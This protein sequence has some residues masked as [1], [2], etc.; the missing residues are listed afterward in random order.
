MKTSY[1]LL[2]SIILLIITY[3]SIAQQGWTIYNNTNTILGSGTYKA[4]SIDQLGNIWVGGSYNGLYK[5][6]GTTWTKYS[7]SNSNILHNDI[8][9]IV[10]D[11]ANKVW[12]ANY[13]GVSVFNGSTFA[14][15]DTLNA[16]F[17]GLT[18]YTLGKDNNGKIWL[19]SRTGS[20]GYKG[21]T[22]FDG[23]TWTNITGYP[24]QINGA[25]FPDFAFASNNDAWIACQNG[26]TK[27]NGAFTYYP[28]VTSISK[29]QSVAIDANGNVWVG[30]FSALVKYNGSTWTK[31][32]N[33]T[34]LGLISSNTLYYDIFPDGNILWIG[35]SGGLLKF[36]ITTGTIV[37]NYNSSNSPLVD[38]CVSKITK[39]ASG[40]LW[41]ATT[42]GVV[43]MDPSIVGVEELD[44][45]N[46]VKIYP[47][48]TSNQ[49]YIESDLSKF[50]ITIIDF[51][52]K[53]IK[54]IKQNTNFVD[55]T[56]LSNGIYFIKVFTVNGTIT[57]KFIKQ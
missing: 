41:L 45:N 23:T 31:Y 8:N 28:P 48:P 11:N 49:L 12:V 25:E 5:F 36:N 51:T 6:N 4:I 39:D 24:S 13:K 15:Y 7:T 21:I 47:N 26:F 22:T 20:F 2:L 52:G 3:P 16:A 38:N 32:D 44:I 40:Y 9:D 50:E 14:N 27:Y 53:T 30:G 19:S 18:V 33:V 42:V 10:I 54:T 1:S 57:K 37:A 17:S 29:S 56:D 35:C 46:Q 34:S 55:I 43:K